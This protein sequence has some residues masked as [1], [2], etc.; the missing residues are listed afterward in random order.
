M[1]GQTLKPFPSRKRR[2]TI[3]ELAV[4]AALAGLLI[5]IIVPVVTSSGENT[6]QTRDIAAVQEAVRRYQ[7]DTGVWPSRD[8]VAPPTEPASNPSMAGELPKSSSVPKFAGINWDTS[9]ALKSGGKTV[10]FAPDYLPVRPRYADDFAKDNTRRWRLDR[11][12][13]VSVEMDGR[14]Y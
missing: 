3:V 4:I 9:A 10:T 6:D 7:A 14:S 13:G 2:F 1:Q 5:A 11:S 8:A 12:G